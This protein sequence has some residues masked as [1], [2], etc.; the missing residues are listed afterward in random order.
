MAIT[1]A[2]SPYL[3]TERHDA[4]VV[5]RPDGSECFRLRLEDWPFAQ[6]LV[7]NLNEDGQEA[8]A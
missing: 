5:L 6:Q 8:R 1:E 3:L 4:L 2:T 7:A